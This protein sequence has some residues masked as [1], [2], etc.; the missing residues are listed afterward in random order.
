MT[1]TCRL[2]IHYRLHHPHIASMKNVFLST[3]NSITYIN[4][5]L[6]YVEGGTLI[7][8]VNGVFTADGFVTEDLAR[9][10]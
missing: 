4:I 1:C 10:G 7:N 6:E 8:Y 5:V 2:R 3:D 9:W